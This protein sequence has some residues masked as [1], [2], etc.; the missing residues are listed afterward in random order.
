MD[1]G[2]RMHLLHTDGR[3]AILLVILRGCSLRSEGAWSRRA[4]APRA[5]HGDLP[6]RDHC[7]GVG[8]RWAAQNT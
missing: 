4:G 1:A 8:S 2:G 5:A 3:D 6:A 7:A